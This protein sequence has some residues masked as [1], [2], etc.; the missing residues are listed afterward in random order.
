MTIK[1]EKNCLNCVHFLTLM[2]LKEPKN[3]ADIGEPESIGIAK[4]PTRREVQRHAFVTIYETGGEPPLESRLGEIPLSGICNRGEWQSAPNF[5]PEDRKNHAE[6]YRKKT[7][8]WDGQE[9]EGDFMG[10]RGTVDSNRNV[11]FLNEKTCRYF[12]SKKKAGSRPSGTI[13]KMQNSRQGR[14]MLILSNILSNILTQTIIF[15]LLV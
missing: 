12:F 5:T 15:F 2:T 14:I 13:I 3:A 8:G 7:R 4:V 1:I 6:E 10:V 11:I 9:L